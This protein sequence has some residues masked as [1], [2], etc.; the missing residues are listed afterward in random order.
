VTTAFTSTENKDSHGVCRCAVWTMFKTRN[1]VS[2]S[3]VSN[4]WRNDGDS[5]TTSTQTAQL[6]PNL[7]Q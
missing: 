3:S 2:T 5:I 6:K 7:T 1:P 4:I